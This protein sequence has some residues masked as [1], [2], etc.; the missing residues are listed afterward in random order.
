MTKRRRRELLAST[1]RWIASIVGANPTAVTKLICRIFGHRKDLRTV[2][3]YDWADKSG[4]LTV[5]HETVV[6]TRCLA[7]I[8]RVLCI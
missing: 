8:K 4:G 7:T 1:R 6:C 5:T 2:I 3:G